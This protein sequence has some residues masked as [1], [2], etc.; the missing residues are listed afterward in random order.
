MNRRPPRTGAWPRAAA[1]GLLLPLLIL[2]AGC[3]AS[4][5][6]YD[7][8]LVLETD[9]GRELGASTEHGIVFLGRSARSGPVSI[10]AEF[11]DGIYGAEAAAKHFFGKHAKDL[12]RQES[13]LL[14]AVLPNPIVRK[15]EKPN[16]E[17]RERQQFVLSQMRMWGGKIDYEEP[18]T[19]KKPEGK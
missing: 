7:P 10:V 6:L 4:R 13:A 12:N 16:A 14:A 8:T 3:K 5:K 18:N 2:A 17:T 1:L 15:V 11:G 9:G 19:P